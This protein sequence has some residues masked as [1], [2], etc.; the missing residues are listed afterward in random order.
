MASIPAS[1]DSTDL[2]EGKKP[3]KWS[4][5][6]TAVQ[7]SAMA[8]DKNRVTQADT[9]AVS[10]TSS[11]ASAAFARSLV[12]FTG[13]L[14]RRPSKLFKPNRVDTWLGL[15][16]LALSTEQ[17]FSPTFLRSLLKQRAGLITVTL[18]I[19]PP[20]LVNATLGF[21][22]FTSHS[23]FSLGLA[24]LP[25][26]QRKLADGEESGEEDINL[27]T[28]VRGPTIIPNHPTILSAIAGAG[29]GLVQGAAF[30]PVE[31]VVR[32]VHQ[33]TTSWATILARLVHLPV[34]NVPAAFDASQPATPMQAMKNL[35]SSDSWK[36][37]RNWWTGWRWA[38]GRDALSYSC[39]FAAFDVTRRV[40]LR[41][42]ALF[43]GDVQGDWDNFLVLDFP[44][45]HTSPSSSSTS[46]RST[47]SSSTSQIGHTSPATYRPMS[48]DPTAPTVARVAQAITIVTG[49]VLASVLA[50][51][52]GRP[53]RACQRIMT[54]DERLRARG[55]ASQLQL[56]GQGKPQP[57]LKPILETLRTKGISPF[58]RREGQVHSSN[59]QEILQKEGKMRRMVKRV[60]WR[61]AAVGPWGFGFL[62]WAW[63]GGEV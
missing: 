24:R 2:P 44:S 22:L 50:E 51:M 46:S 4:S 5:V 41:V 54:A 42:K 10:S 13:F 62:V 27:E 15:R 25:F 29:A 20:M 56:Q 58:L 60:G 36:K 28:L 32:F 35:F 39:F 49:G 52:V 45:T 31:N 16:Q 48:T 47:T 19:I 1:I 7:M 38:I 37:N 43:G 9:L 26:F 23:L 21:L 33:S 12:L 6:R 55:E 40:G 53:F 63:V 61:M 11:S 34:P 17:S 18:T 8:K 30:T 57:R 3:S 59:T 14:F